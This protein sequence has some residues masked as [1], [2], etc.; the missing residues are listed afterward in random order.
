MVTRRTRLEELVARFNTLPQAKFYIEHMG[1]N[2]RDYED[3]HEVFSGVARQLLR[4]LEGL[5]RRVQR[6]RLDVSP[7][8]PLRPGR[9]GGRP[10][11]R[12]PGGEHRQVPERSGDHQRQPRPAA[13]IDG[14]LLP[15]ARQAVAAVARLL[16]RAAVTE[17][18]MA[19]ATLNDGQRLL[20]FNDFVGQRT[21]VSARCWPDLA[22][23]DGGAIVERRA[24]FDRRGLD[25]LVEFDAE[26]RAGGL[27]SAARRWS[28]AGAE[29]LR[30]GWDD[31]RLALVVR[32]P[33]R[34]RSSSV[35]AD[36]P[37]VGGRRGVTLRVAHA[38][39]R[40]AFLR[41]R[42]AGR[43]GVQ[44]RRRGDGA[45]RRPQGTAGGAHPGALAMEAVACSA[46]GPP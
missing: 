31:P 29:P 11:S 36:R 34:S 16:D 23:A 39:T 1:L 19:E 5:G 17:I 14:V 15:F 43:P 32:E 13:Q 28:S 6:P 25:R 30:L 4:D 40:R 26:H 2:F 24:G 12:R 3:E 38:G 20:A 7:R 10:R 22:G 18:T 42:R 45:C 44:L 27:R 35:E 21:H 41:R 8:L 37:S 9:R 33:F 46:R